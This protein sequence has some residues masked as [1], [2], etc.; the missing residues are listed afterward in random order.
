VL[1]VFLACRLEAEVTGD[2][3][4]ARSHKALKTKGPAIEKELFMMALCQP[5][6][7]ERIADFER[8]SEILCRGVFCCYVYQ[9]RRFFSLLL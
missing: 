2:D 1:Q 8:S 9:D 7:E 3:S 4:T 6:E 5:E